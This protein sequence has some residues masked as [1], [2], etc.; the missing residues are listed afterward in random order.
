MSKIAQN[1]QS[2][3]YDQQG[4]LIP[5]HTPKLN[6]HD[7]AAIRREL[8]AL[9]RDARSGNIPTQD[10]TRLGYLL[11]LIRKGF[12]TAALQDRIEL[13]ERTIEHRRKNHEK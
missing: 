1:E 13:L 5:P 9:Y 2:S 11:D 8:C 7:A 3:T 6:L 10:A 12:E 4:E